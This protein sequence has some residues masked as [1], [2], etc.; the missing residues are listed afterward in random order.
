MNTAD[1]E[2]SAYT[3]V[4]NCPFFYMSNYN[5]KFSILK[6]AGYSDER[7]PNR[8]IWGG[9]TSRPSAEQWAGCGELV[10]GRSGATVAVDPA[11]VIAGDKSGAATLHLPDSAART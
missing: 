10:A 4:P 9:L 3:T 1:H 2:D 6:N 8:L 11:A 5:S 7:F